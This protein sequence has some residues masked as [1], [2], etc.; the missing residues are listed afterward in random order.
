MFYM[1]VK[2]VTHWL[3]VALLGTAWICVKGLVIWLTI[4]FGFF[5]CYCCLCFLFFVFYLVI[6]SVFQKLII[7][8]R[9]PTY[10]LFWFIIFTPFILFL[11]FLLLN[12]LGVSSIYHYYLALNISVCNSKR[13]VLF[14]SHNAIINFI[15]LHWYNIFIAQ[16]QVLAVD[17][18]RSFICT[19]SI[20]E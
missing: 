7:I 15:K 10:S 6:L 5:F 9:T 4:E 13:D 19:R 1:V 14:N 2:I 8:Q 11:S 12:C 20:V 16:I 3:L 18:M 17:L